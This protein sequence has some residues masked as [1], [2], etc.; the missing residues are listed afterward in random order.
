MILTN[1]QK[2]WLYKSI[3]QGPVNTADLIIFGNEF[4]SARGKGDT[5][6]SINQFINEFKTR[7]LL[8]I[9]DGF[10]VIDIDSPPVT[11]SFLQYISRLAL[12]LKH[13]DDRFFGEFSAEGKAFLNKY[14]MNSLYRENTA[15]INFRPLLQP[16]ESQWPYENISENVYHNIFDFTVKNLHHDQ[17]LDMRVSILKAAFDMIKKDAIVLGSGDKENKKAFFKTIYPTIQFKEEKLSETYK[18]YHSNN[19]DKKIILSNYFDNRTL[20]LENLELLY[21]FICE[22]N[23][24]KEHNI[25]ATKLF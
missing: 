7:K 3:G 4:G 21:N 17:L 1:E 5:E 25:I 18:I 23:L 8:Q 12:A 15:V 24:P 6:S 2:N 22:F 13:K 14:I 19:I 20:G 11:S 10:T 9:A 16:T